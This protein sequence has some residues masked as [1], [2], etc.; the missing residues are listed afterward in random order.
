MG[1]LIPIL[2]LC[3]PV[4]AIALNGVQKVYR[5]RIEE[6]R[7]RAGAYGEGGAAELELLRGEVDELRRELGEV[8]ERLD[9]TERLLSRYPD[10]DRLAGG[11]GSEGA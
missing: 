5:L 7:I 2:A 1:V 6:A 10:R 11:P 9:F 4:L 8:H 3:I